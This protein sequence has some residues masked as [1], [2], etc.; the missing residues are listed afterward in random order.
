MQL[1]P[2]PFDEAKRIDAVYCTN[3]LDSEPEER[4]DRI[5]RIAHR[6]F[7]IPSVFITLVDKNRVWFKSRYGCDV[8]EEPRDVSIC[9]HTICNTV[10]D[11][12]SSRL[13]EV[14]D[15]KSDS[16]F[17]DNSFITK[18]CGL[19]YYM[20]FVLQ[21][22]NYCNIGTLCMTDL[23]PRTFSELDKKLFSDLGLM[24]EAE[25]NNNRVVAQ[26]GISNFLCQM[27]DEKNPTR[28]ANQFLNFSDTLN[29]KLSVLNKVLKKNGINYKEWRILNEIA[30]RESTSPQIVSQRL[31][32]SA[33]LVSKYLESLEL[34]GLI[35]RKSPREGDRRF[36]H[37]ECSDLG[38]EIWRKGINI[39]NNLGVNYLD[40]MFSLK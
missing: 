35:D 27:I 25:L 39:A 5:T 32:M 37:I 11:D 18:T 26:T 40:E 13:F 34:Q 6:L 30:Q 22:A 36:V 1:A 31:D 7:D 2:L 23:R 21:S 24:A 28:F 33:P 8:N 3:I 10:A 15:V 14:I 20:G 17:Y 19:R 12:M 38:K 4:F 29:S 9:G 16:R